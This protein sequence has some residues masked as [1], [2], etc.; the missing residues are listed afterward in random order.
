MDVKSVAKVS[1][2]LVNNATEARDEDRRQNR[3]E[4]HGKSAKAKSAVAV[5]PPTD[6]KDESSE[7]DI[8]CQIIDSFKLVE[9]LAHKTLTSNARQAAFT[10]KAVQAPKNNSASDG[11]KVNKSF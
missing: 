9:M 7:T 6:T 1:P 3:D 8:T 4:A 5:A 10:S 2:Y 11:K